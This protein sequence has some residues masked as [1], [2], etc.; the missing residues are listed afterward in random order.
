VIRAAE[1]VRRAADLGVRGF[2]VFDEG[3]LW[4]LDRMRE[5]GRLP[6]EVRFKAS[7]GMGAGNPVHCRVV[8]DL[9]A[10]A[11]NLQRD[12]ELSMIAAVR[13]AVSI[14]LDLHTDNPR[15][16]GGFI[17]TYEVGEIVRVA[18]PVYLKSGNSQKEF[19]EG[20]LTAG[21]IR[22][23]AHQIAVESEMIARY[24]PETAQSRTRDF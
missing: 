2:L 6:A 23:I 11:I 4:L 9:G 15:A 12:L 10:D 20:A 21:Q 1:D 24:H 8:A 14:P 17:R 13:Q 7:S 5:D 19:E 18:A 22:G 3:H 16:T